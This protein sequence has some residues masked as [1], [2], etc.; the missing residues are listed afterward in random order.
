MALARAG[1]NSV[2]C[3]YD[4]VPQMDADALAP[5]ITRAARPDYQ[6]MADLLAFSWPGGPADRTAPVAREWLRRW[7]PRALVGE[8]A[9]CA[10]PDGRC[11]CSN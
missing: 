11:A 5:L 8:G 1:M 9:P 10:C 3:G 2:P 4:G 6:L 7:S